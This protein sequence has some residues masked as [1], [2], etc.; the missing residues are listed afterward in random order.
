[1]KAKRKPYSRSGLA[2]QLGRWPTCF[3]RLEEKH[4]P[5][6]H[7]WIMP[8]PT[9]KHCTATCPH[10]VKTLSQSVRSTRHPRINCNPHRHM[11]MSCLC[12]STWGPLGKEEAS[13]RLQPLE[14]FMSIW[15]GSRMNCSSSGS[16][17]PGCQ[18]SWE[19]HSS[20]F[21]TWQPIKRWG[22][23]IKPVEKNNHKQE[24]TVKATHLSHLLM[25]MAF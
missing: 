10:T 14:Q 2:S 12:T 11:H 17:T 18:L 13:S 8:I 4:L 24:T 5:W 19:P 6:F 22:G 23:T 21:T 16:L 7:L 20:S 15:T 9:W 25:P 1:M 3:E